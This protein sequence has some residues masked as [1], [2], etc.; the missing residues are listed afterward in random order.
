MQRSSSTNWSGKA[1]HHSLYHLGT[2]KNESSDGIIQGGTWLWEVRWKRWKQS[3]KKKGQLFLACDPSWQVARPETQ[4]LSSSP[5]Q[6]WP[7]VRHWFGWRAGWR[8][9]VLPNGKWECIMLQYDTS[10]IPRQSHRHVRWVGVVLQAQCCK[11]ETTGL[12]GKTKP[13][14][15][16]FGQGWII[17]AESNF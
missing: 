14:R 11:E 5:A 16:I 13:H 6:S 12:S 9:W 15:S 2:S 8:D 1:S 7:F 4:T 10:T 3:R 17:S